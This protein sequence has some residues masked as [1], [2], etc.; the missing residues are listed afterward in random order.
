MIVLKLIFL[1]VVWMIT[2][3]I[4][5]LGACHKFGGSCG[6]PSYDKLDVVLFVAI[7]AILY[8]VFP[9]WLF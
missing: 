4:F 1:I 3:P 9:L 7:A 8:I 2:T 6:Y 5:T